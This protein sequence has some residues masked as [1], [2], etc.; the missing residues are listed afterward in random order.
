MN[1]DVIL[2]LGKIAGLSL[3]LFLAACWT[4]AVSFS[5]AA[6]TEGICFMLF[7]RYCCKR[8]NNENVTVGMI[9]C[10]V[11]FGRI[12]IE[13]PIRIADFN[14]TLIS[15]PVLFICIVGILMGLL[16]YQNSNRYVWLGCII[17]IAVY[18]IFVPDLWCHYFW[19]HISTDSN[20]IVPD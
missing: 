18:S 16:C 19:H 4:A 13:M 3:L 9:T 2:I 15:L 10:A 17:V 12:I 8:Y 5:L 7:T 14:G 6:A 20:V 1:K 11:I